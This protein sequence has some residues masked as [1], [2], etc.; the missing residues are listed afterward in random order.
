M[1]VVASQKTGT[2]IVQ[3]SPSLN[4]LVIQKFPVNKD[5]QCSLASSLWN[6]DYDLA[7]LK[8]IIYN[9]QDCQALL[10]SYQ[11]VFDSATAKF[12]PKKYTMLFKLWLSGRSLLKRTGTF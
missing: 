6:T 2:L 4:M 3:Q 8:S 5:Y 7:Q 12:M 11:Q 10:V 9:R 1:Y